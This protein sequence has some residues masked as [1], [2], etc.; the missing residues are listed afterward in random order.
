MADI[1]FTFK[2]GDPIP[3][4]QI[5]LYN[6]PEETGLEGDI[7][8]FQKP[9]WLTIAS[10]RINDTLSIAINVNINVQPIGSYDETIIVYGRRLVGFGFPPEPDLIFEEYTIG[11]FD[12]SL[13]LSAREPIAATPL[14]FDFYHK[15]GNAVLPV[16]QNLSVTSEKPFTVT[17]DQPWITVTPDNANG[18]ATI[19][20]GV[21][22]QGL[23]PGTYNGLVN[24]QDGIGTI[25]IPVTLVV[26][27]QLGGEDFLFTTPNEINFE[28]TRF[29]FLPTS[30]N[31]SVNASGPFSIETEASWIAVS[32]SSGNQNTLSFD[33]D[34]NSD[35]DILGIGV[36]VSEVVLK[37]GDIV[38]KVIVKVDISQFIENLFDSD[39]LY[40]T[41]DDNKIELVSSG[42][43]S[44][45][46]VLIKA[47]NRNKL[48]RFKYAIPF[49]RG[50]S[51]TYIGGELRKIIGK[52]SP[53]DVSSTFISTVYAPYKS[54]L[55][56]FDITE[57]KIY[58]DVILRGVQLNDIRFIKGITPPTNKL[59][60]LPEKVF[61]TKQG[62][63]S[64]SFLEQKNTVPN[65]ITISGDVQESIPVSIT[66]N[67]FYSVLLPIHSI[68]GLNLG[69]E[70]K[71]SVSGVETTVQI[72]PSGIDH[73]V[74][75]WENQWGCWD[76]FECTGQIRA[77]NK[78]GYTTEEY[79]KNR[80][81]LVKEV[82][83]TDTIGGF[84]IDTGWLYSQAEVLY[85]ETLLQSRNIF[86]LI[87]GELIEVINKT[88]SFNNY[89]TR[90]F[91]KSFKLT[92][93]KSKR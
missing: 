21:S 10:D 63:L 72:K 81:T 87:D 18:N 86:L 43:N 17:K 59:T 55:T 36:F 50:I 33:I 90:R 92:F 79:Y 47:G 40:F 26:D 58:S 75:F 89:V 46:S 51:T 11:T 61:M 78:Y 53:P 2:K 28:Y 3:E 56:D 4:P 1:N 80:N 27:G 16:N 68:S 62:I 35:A 82:L 5:L 30:R 91:K 12:V 44:Q 67:D 9:N 41:D 66:R 19:E 25:S 88:T 38:S 34:I 77:R 54:M 60:M 52:L 70:F 13:I 45:L 69:D 42:G 83:E 49:F 76:T 14:E 37:L 73:C 84:D 15:V 71:V 57:N 23:V 39:T 93:E 64:Y 8:S 48:F 31:I 7:I 74:I 65:A 20:V 24:L 22:V 32:Q 6:L 85:L 29:G